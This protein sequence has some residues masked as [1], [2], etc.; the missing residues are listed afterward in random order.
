MV[1]ILLYFMLPCVTSFVT[2]LTHKPT[3]PAVDYVVLL[4][5]K[6]K[7]ANFFWKQISV[8]R[9]HRDGVYRLPA[10]AIAVKTSHCD[11]FFFTASM[12]MQHKANRLMERWR[13]S[14]NPTP[15]C[16]CTSFCLGRSCDVFWWKYSAVWAQVSQTRAKDSLCLINARNRQADLSSNFVDGQE[17]ANWIRIFF[18]H[19]Q[20]HDIN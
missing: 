19:V 11:V 4:R 6:C 16:S 10:A 17:R 13:C 9:S 14:C 1:A 15:T 20:Y 8:V 2:R 12:W 3:E 7:H 5:R 18:L